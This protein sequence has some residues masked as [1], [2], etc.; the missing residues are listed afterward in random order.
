[1]HI[2]LLE[3]KDNKRLKITKRYSEEGQ[4]IIYKNTNTDNK[5]VSN[6]NPPKNQGELMYT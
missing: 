3:L 5:R 1:M 6:A 2:T 4:L